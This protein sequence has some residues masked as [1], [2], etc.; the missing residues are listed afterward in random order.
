MWGSCVWGERGGRWQ[1][2]GVVWYSP[3]VCAHPPR[4]GV[5]PERCRG[6]VGGSARGGLWSALAVFSHTEWC[7]AGRSVVCSRGP[8]PPP[9]G[10]VASSASLPPRSSARRVCRRVGRPVD[11]GGGVARPGEFE[12][13]VP[14]IAHVCSRRPRCRSCCPGG[15]DLRGRLVGPACRALAAG[16]WGGG[17]AHR[18]PPP[19]RHLAGTARAAARRGEV[20]GE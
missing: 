14:L 16:G 9:R 13:A 3:G 19:L 2:G 5:L 12:S 17:R 6:R 18:P 11:K 20:A 15:L 1:R 8:A 7:E 10:G 4:L